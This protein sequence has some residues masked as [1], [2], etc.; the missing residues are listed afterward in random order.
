MLANLLRGGALVW[1]L[2]QCGL[3]MAVSNAHVDFDGDGRQDL[4]WRNQA[5]GHIAAWRM[6]GLSTPARAILLADP[7]WRVVATPDLDGDGKTDLI[8]HNERTGRFAGWLMNGLAIF[9]GKQEIAVIGRL[10]A[11]HH[12]LH[13]EQIARLVFKHG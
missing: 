9:L 8:W 10:A 5:T 12:F 1:T 2:L 6:T 11:V 4:L 3:S 13:A 7:A